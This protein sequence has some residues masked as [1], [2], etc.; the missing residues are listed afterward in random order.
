MQYSPEDKNESLQRSVRKG[1]FKND[2]RQISYFVSR[3][4]TI[5]GLRNS[6]TYHSPVLQSEHY[7]SYI[8]EVLCL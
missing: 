7:L 8:P 4:A 5:S 1:D 2:V 6:A 3:L